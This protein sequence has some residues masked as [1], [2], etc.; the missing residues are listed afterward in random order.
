MEEHFRK[1]KL[2][3]KR[4]VAD[5]VFRALGIFEKLPSLVYY[6]HGKNQKMQNKIYSILETSQKKY[7]PRVQKSH[8]KLVCF[9]SNDEYF[10]KKST[11]EEKENSNSNS[12]STEN[13]NMEDTKTCEPCFSVCGDVH[14]QFY[15]LLNSMSHQFMEIF[16]FF[17]KIV[18]KLNGHPSPTNPYLFNGDFVDR[19]SFSA[20]V[21][22]N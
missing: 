17:F 22:E 12:N 5:I 6:S 15:D 7:S 1:E 14:G 18:F 10:G 8:E 9:V 4:I 13:S 16:L 19:G 3:H 21:C 20:E 11:T 2:L